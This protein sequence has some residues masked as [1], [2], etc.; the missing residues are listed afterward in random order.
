MRN[1]LICLV[2]LSASVLVAG[3]SQVISITA[4]SQT[5]TLEVVKYANPF[6]GLIDEITVYAPSG[7]T[8][9]VAV[10][11]VDPYSG[12]SLVLATNDVSGS[13]VWR[14]RVMDTSLTG[15]VALAITNS[16]SSAMYNA[17]GEAIK[18]T[19]NGATKTGSVFRVVIKTK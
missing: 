16:A 18:A 10:A 8:G 19:L 6:I 13:M 4:N 7:V 17:C 9:S 11:A 14:P 15:D 5:S 12:A 3:E 1:L 2:I